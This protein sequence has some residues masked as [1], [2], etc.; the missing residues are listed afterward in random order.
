MSM[1]GREKAQMHPI[2]QDSAPTEHYLVE[3]S[4]RLGQI[5]GFQL[6]RE[7]MMN[8]MIEEKTGD[9]LD[10]LMISEKSQN[11]LLANINAVLTGLDQRSKEQTGRLAAHLTK[12]EQ[13]LE[14]A[15]KEVQHLKGELLNGFLNISQRS[16]VPL[17]HRLAMLGTIAGSSVMGG[18]IV[19]LVMY[20]LL[21][22][23]TGPS[24]KVH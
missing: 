2:A 12:K 13:D 5:R 6:D 15:L 20:L 22:P 17:S 1:Q 8:R 7:H 3:I 11:E 14:T 21:W 4:E 16:K 9:L 19:F 24:P 18:L 23:H 10:K